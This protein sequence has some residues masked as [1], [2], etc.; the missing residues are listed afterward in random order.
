MSRAAPLRGSILVNNGKKPHTFT[1][2]QTKHGS[3]T[4]TGFVRTLKPRGQSV[5]LLFLDSR[6]TIAW[7]GTLPADRA[8]P[9]M[10]GTFRVT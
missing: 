4:Q 10:Q 8:K 1:F 3:R 9:R 6:G 5:L 7:A 2:G